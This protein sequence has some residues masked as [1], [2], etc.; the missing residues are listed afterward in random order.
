MT[1]LEALILGLV[2]GLTEFLPI[3]SSAHLVLAPWLLGWSFDPPAKFAFDVLVQGG[4]LVAVLAFYRRDL[5]AIG[6]A[7]L[8]GLARRQPLASAEAR[9][10]WLIALATLPAVAAGL[11][12]KDVVEAAFGDPRWT[13]ANLLVT[14]ALL[15]VSEWRA[16]RRRA[17]EGLTWSDALLIGMAQALALL[18][19]IS[20]SGATIA[21]GLARGL[22]RSSAARF[23]FLMAVPALAGGSAVAFGDLMALQDAAE[24]AV[25]VAA[26]FVCAGIVGYLC[27]RWLIGYL[28]RRSLY[29][30]SVYC[31]LAGLFCLAV[32]FWRA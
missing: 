6:L 3:S 30:F 21:G 23:S 32:G 29:G 20:R 22:D 14:A 19:G 18:P 24:F 12:F 1:I 9:L 11:V 2:Q 7:V 27:I 8:A 10:G 15:A 28:S 25:P 5:W 13:A 4:T 16:G 17:L 26:G 31:A